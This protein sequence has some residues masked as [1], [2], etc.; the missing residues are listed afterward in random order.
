MG[1]SETL[2]SFIRQVASNTNIIPSALFRS[3]GFISCKKGRG[4]KC[5]YKPTF[6]S[7]QPKNKTTLAYVTDCNW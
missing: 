2:Q 5:A 4:R 3:P 1:A 7:F 6:E